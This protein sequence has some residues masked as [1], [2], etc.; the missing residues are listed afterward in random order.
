MLLMEIAGQFHQLGA[1]PLRSA[2]GAGL[3]HSLTIRSP[4]W[5]TP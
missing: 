5:S 3:H 1:S 4:R 2:A